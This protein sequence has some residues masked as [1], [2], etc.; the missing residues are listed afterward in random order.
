MAASASWAWFLVVNRLIPLAATRRS[1]S[2]SLGG[3]RFTDDGAIPVTVSGGLASI[4]CVTLYE[5]LRG[6]L[7]AMDQAGVDYALAGGL[8]VAVWG[9][10][11]ATKDIDLLV[12]PADVERAVTA[13]RARGF[14][15]DALPFEFKDGTTL[16]RVNKIDAGGNLMTVDLIVVDQ[17]LASAWASRIRLPFGDS[18]VVV[19]SREALIAMKALAGRPQDVADIQN[20]QEIDR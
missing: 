7:A 15:L 13:I 12:Q 17:N 6:V 16:R 18:H 20:L 2:F 11:R 10:P 5:E 4:G 8:A 1:T 19:I 14:T 9:A 3:D